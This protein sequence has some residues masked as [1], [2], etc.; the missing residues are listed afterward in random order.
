MAAAARLAI[1]P[2]QIVSPTP[3]QVDEKFK[4]PNDFLNFKLQQ[5]L[6]FSLLQILLIRLANLQQ[7]AFS[8]ALG[9]WI[10]VTNHLPVTV[11]KPG[12]SC[13]KVQ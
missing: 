11:T 13:R 1:W 12:H 7:K 8:F 3:G 2:Q 9:P 10:T 5:Q 6:G 4:T